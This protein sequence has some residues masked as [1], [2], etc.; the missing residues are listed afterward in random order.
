MNVAIPIWQ[1]RVSPVFDVAGQ[2]LVARIR[3]GGVEISG[4]VPVTA[5]DPQA[6]LEVLQEAGV[7]VLI[8][9]AISRSMERAICAAGIEVISQTCGQVQ[10]VLAAYLDGR[11]QR[12]EFLMPGCCRRRKRMRS[13]GPG[14][15]RGLPGGPDRK[16]NDYAPR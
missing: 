1:N 13:R 12:G 3:K 9:G 11:L 2:V 16:G 8:C 7:D 15:R 6:R 5:Q 4:Q 14:R 10:S